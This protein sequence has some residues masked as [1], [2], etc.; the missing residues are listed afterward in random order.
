VDGRAPNLTP[1]ET[2]IEDIVFS[3]ISSDG[4]NQLSRNRRCDRVETAMLFAEETIEFTI[5]PDIHAM[6]KRLVRQCVPSVKSS[7]CA[8]AI[9]RGLGF[10]TNIALKTT[11]DAAGSFVATPDRTA[12]EAFL[13][14]QGH[15]VAALQAAL[16]PDAVRLAAGEP[17]RML[18][19]ERLLEFVCLNCLDAFPASAYSEAQCAACLSRKGRVKGIN[20]A[21]SI[22][23]RI[24]LHA[25]F[26]DEGLDEWAYL[27]ARPGWHDFLSDRS[28]SSEVERL[29]RIRGEIQK[30]EFGGVTDPMIDH[31]FVCF[32]FEAVMLALDVPYDELPAIW[33]GWQGKPEGLNYSV[34]MGGN[35]LN[36]ELNA[37]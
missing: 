21:E 24:P 28:L 13:A 12:F 8:E 33:E 2:L 11:L 30:G 9:A 37:L 3:S 18:A 5:D 25:F 29:R 15:D 32:G 26:L 27:G 1:G 4:F 17:W 36:G 22:R 31:F 35:F 23:R 7:H 10:K 6:I 19:G 16:L 34:K 20:H 14:A